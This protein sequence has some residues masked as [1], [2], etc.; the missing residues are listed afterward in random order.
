[1]SFAGVGYQSYISSHISAGKWLRSLWLF[2]LAL[3]E[4]FID[5]GPEYSLFTSQSVF[6]NPYN[7]M[8]DILENMNTDK[9]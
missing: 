4:S 6:K 5:L 3:S 8:P 7:G 2:S 1:M 9:M